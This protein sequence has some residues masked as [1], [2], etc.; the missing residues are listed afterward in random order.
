[1]ADRRGGRWSL[2]GELSALDLVVED[3]IAGSE[4][5]PGALA[6]LWSAVDCP[7]SGDVLVSAAPGYEF[8]DWGGADHVPGGSHGSLDAGDSLGVLLACGVEAPP[9]EEWSI[10]DAM[11]LILR[12]F[13]ISS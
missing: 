1:V 2:E 5:Y 4:R 8:V 12:H 9:R 10:A 11:G 7:T 3:G 13:S 6:R